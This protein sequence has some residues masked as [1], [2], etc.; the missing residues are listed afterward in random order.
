MHKKEW[1][2]PLTYPQTHTVDNSV[3]GHVYPLQYRRCNS[4]PLYGDAA[5]IKTKMISY[6]R[7]YNS[8][9][10]A[11]QHWER[12]LANKPILQSRDMERHTRFELVTSTLARLRSTN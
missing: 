3:D 8:G 5:S 6:L 10:N 2:Y 7:I 11:S 12:A 1:L 9:D 4:I